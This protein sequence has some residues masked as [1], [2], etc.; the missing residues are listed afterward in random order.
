M[1]KNPYKAYNQASHTVAKTRQVVMLYDG[2]IRNLQQACEAMKHNQVEERFKKLLRAS[3][4]IIGLQSSLDFENGES[5]ARILYDFYSSIDS[6]MLTLHRTCDIALCNTLIEEL[7]EVREMWDK[8][9]RGETQH[10]PVPQGAADPS[11]PPS[12]IPYA[13][14]VGAEHRSYSSNA[15][16]T[17]PALS[18]TKTFEA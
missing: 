17:L 3:E 15:S 7:K 2:V 10:T 1:Q 18:P 12:S 13:A 5:A 4:I 16:T 6:R 11:P 8:I 9:D 14:T